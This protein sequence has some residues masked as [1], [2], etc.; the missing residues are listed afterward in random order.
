MPFG[1]PACCIYYLNTLHF[2]LGEV[3]AGMGILRIQQ[4]LD[5]SPVVSQQQGALTV[6]VQPARSIN[7]SRKTELVKGTMSPLRRELTQYS[8]GFI[9]QDYHNGI[10]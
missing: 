7:S 1:V 5:Q 10:S 4:L 9:E 3:G 6:M 2:Y 8:E